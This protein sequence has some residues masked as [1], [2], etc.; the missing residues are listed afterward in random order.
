MSPIA[1]PAM[2]IAADSFSRNRR[3]TPNA[4]PGQLFNSQS[5]QYEPVSTGRRGSVRKDQNFRAPSVLQR[6][7]QSDARKPAEPSPAFQ[8]NRAAGAPEVGIWTRRGSSTVSGDSGSMNRKASMNRGVDVPRMP[9]EILQQRR[10]SQPLHSPAFATQQPFTDST[11]AAASPQQQKASPMTSSAVPQAIDPKEAERKH[12]AEREQQRKA[13]LEK[14]ELAIKRRAEQE[15][16]EEAEKKERIRL[17]MQELGLEP[18]PDKNARKTPAP[19]VDQVEDKSKNIVEEDGRSGLTEQ[20]PVQT[21]PR[22]D[23]AAPTACSPPK[24]PM[25]DGSGEPK[26]YGMMKVHGQLLTNGITSREG[27]WIPDRNKEQAHNIEAVL[28]NRQ[29]PGQVAKPST[30]PPMV[31]G[32]VSVKLPDTPTV[33]DP[34]QRTLQPKP[35]RPQPWSTLPSD[36]VSYK[37]WN[38]PSMTTHSAAGGNLWGP[39]SNHKA[40]GNGTFDQSVQRPQSRQAPYQ[41]QFKSPAPQPIGPPKSM[42]RSRQSP[43]AARAPEVNSHPIEDMQ[44]IPTFPSTDTSAKPAS[45]TETPSGIQPPNA[46]TAQTTSQPYAAPSPQVVNMAQRRLNGDEDLKSTLAAWGDF[47]LTSARENEEK[48]R[49]NAQREAARIAEEARTGVRHVPQ[50]PPMQET[51]KQVTDQGGQRET[52]NVTKRQTHQQSQPFSQVNSDLMAR[53]F[54]AE[55]N[56]MPPLNVGRNS[57]FFPAHGHGLQ[58]FNPR[59]V[60]LPIGYYRQPSPPPP[61][62]V[63]HPAYAGEGR[64]LVNLPISKPK[65]TVRLPPSTVTPAQSP[66]PAPVTA[67]PLRAISQPLVNNPSWQ[68]RFNGLLGVAKKPSPEKKFAQVVDFSASTKVPLDHTV[69]VTPASVSLPP[70]IEESAASKE[71]GKVTSKDVEDEEELFEDRGFG[72]VPQVSLPAKA[73][74]GVGFVT[75]TKPRRQTKTLKAVESESKR[76]FEPDP[77]ENQMGEGLLIYISLPGMDRRSKM[78]PRIKGLPGAQPSTHSGNQRQ[79]RHVSNNQK[80]R[81][82]PKPRESSGHYNSSSKHSQGGSQ[83]NTTQSN[84]GTQSRGHQGSQRGPMPNWYH[85]SPSVHGKTGVLV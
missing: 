7:S 20:Q 82:P 54:V 24:P 73:P 28:D 79:Q 42:Q 38:G 58:G 34:G 71:A 4:P 68:D 6:P 30:E 27:A 41:E 8:S 10:D 48:R 84:P 75:A 13:M 64:P 32:V 14:R 45:T 21:P 76:G 50:L 9:D 36:E 62:T 83:R 53:P 19:A 47:H 16:K 85:N 40:L 66:V 52:V 5:G 26:Q 12:A 78:L 1:Q 39:P 69:T 18:I 43:E 31:N 51:W 61:D 22:A 49:V 37:S 72:S 29:L 60:S 25:P 67:V 55:P 15:A 81:G 77:R 70:S 11:S 57:R 56:M 59:A 80:P 3:D 44:T 35:T 17:K 65:P 23:G 2:E 63:G 74:E 46:Q 33:K